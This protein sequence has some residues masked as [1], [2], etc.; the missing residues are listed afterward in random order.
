MKVLI[1]GTRTF[2]DIGLM[3]KELYYFLKNCEITEVV[4]GNSGNA[5]M[6]GEAWAKSH[7]INLKVFP[8]DWK[9]HGKAAGPIRNS[10]MARYLEPGDKAVI[11]WDGKSRGTKDM[12]DKAT[13][14]LGETNVC[15]VYYLTPPQKSITG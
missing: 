10:E 7:K 2:N 14:K 5:D 8:A 15:V 3:G 6:F 13:A 1:A 4:S 9:K 11:F 12:I